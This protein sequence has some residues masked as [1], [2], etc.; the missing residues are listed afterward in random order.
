MARKSKAQGILIS[1]VIGIA[2]A[3]WLFQ[4]YPVLTGAI[5]VIFIVGA[6]LSSKSDH[7]DIC[8]SELKRKV[9]T[10]EIEGETKEIC[11]N[12]NRE[13]EKKRSKEAIEN[14]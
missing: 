3:I 1:V 8:D 4:N 10:C 14:L 13:L 11:P 12:C 9:Y 5:V 6:I 2:G 7:C